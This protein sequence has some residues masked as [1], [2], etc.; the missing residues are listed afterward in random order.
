MCLCAADPDYPAK[1]WDH[2]LPR[3]TLNLNLLC[4]LCFN[5]KSSAYLALHGIFYYNKNRLLLLEP[6]SQTIRRPK[7]V[8]LGPLM[9][10][11][12]VTL[13][14]TQ[15]TIDAWNATPHQLTAHKFQ[16]P[17]IF[18][19][20]FSFSQDKFRGLSLSIYWRYYCS[21]SKLQAY[22][23]LTFIWGRYTKLNNKN[24]N[25]SQPQNFC[26]TSH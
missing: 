4:D 25:T 8:L 21:I 14:R 18:F 26:T 16:T 7:T 10:L 2:F 9:I 17:S 24:K 5:P 13:V 15:S 1:Q 19:I 12:D 11:T 22:C 3:A 23:Y 6:D 20:N